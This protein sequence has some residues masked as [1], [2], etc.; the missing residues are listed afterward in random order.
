MAPLISPISMYKAVTD[1]HKQQLEPQQTVIHPQGYRLLSTGM[2]NYEFPQTDPIDPKYVEQKLHS[3]IATIC[4]IT[5]QPTLDAKD[6]ETKARR[7]AGN[8][9]SRLPQANAGYLEGNLEF[10]MPPTLTD[11]FAGAYLMSNPIKSDSIEGNDGD[12]GD[13]G[14]CETGIDIGTDG[15]HFEVQE[16]YED[17]DQY[18]PGGEGYVKATVD[19]QTQKKKMRRF[20]LSPNQTRFLMSEFSRQAHP[21]AAHRA[22]LSKEIPG[23]SPR[24][25]QVWFQN[26]RAKLK[27]L[28]S[29]DREKVLILRTSADDFDIAQAGRSPYGNWHQASNTLTSLGNYFNFNSPQERGDILTPLMIDIAGSP[30]DEEYAT[31]PLSPSSTCGGYLP[32]PTSA[33]A[34][35]SEPEFSLI[36]TE[37]DRAA[38]YASF[39]NQQPSAP[40]YIGPFTRSR[41]FPNAFSQTPYLHSSGLHQP[42]RTRP[43]AGSLGSP[44]QASISYTQTITDYGTPDYSSLALDMPYTTQLFENTV[45]QTCTGINLGQ[46]PQ[47]ELNGL[48][49]SKPASLRLRTMPTSLPLESHAKTEYTQSSHPLQSAP[50]SGNTP[51]ED[52]ISPLSTTFDTNPFGT[53]FCERN[54]SSSSLPVPF[55]PFGSTGNLQADFS[56]H[57]DFGNSIDMQ[58]PPDELRNKAY[59]SGFGFPE[60]K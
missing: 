47:S 48:G 58:S 41:S 18:Q 32:S 6:T 3:G 31:S 51:H 29:N 27:R 53:S 34:S 14:D 60:T 39:S 59:P 20:R 5:N 54:S 24:Q 12:A 40:R 25:V 26:R 23:L 37:G 28:T 46:A 43:R 57:E 1:W 36:S 45:S 9:G 49:P 13:E 22:R 11:S 44:L 4:A 15:D 10:S 55:F 19:R 52:Q 7:E 38:L 17:R 2:K 30:R 35:G 8:K 33:S 16:S 42:D 21:D 56:T 50:L